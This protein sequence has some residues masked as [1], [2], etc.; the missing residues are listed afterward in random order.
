MQSA[1][2]HHRSLHQGRHG[3]Q[4]RARTPK[5]F[6]LAIEVQGTSSLPMQLGEN[7]RLGWQKKDIWVLKPERPEHGGRSPEALERSRIVDQGAAQ[8]HPA[9]DL[10]P[11]PAGDDFHSSPS[12]AHATSSCAGPGIS[13]PG[14]MSSRSRIITGPFS[15]TR[16]SWRLPCV[17][18]CILLALPIA[19]GLATRFK[20][21][22]NE[23]KILIT[24]AFITDATLKTFG[25]VLF[26]DKNGAANYLLG[27]WACRGDGGL[28]VHRLGDACWAWSTICCPS[29]SSPS[30]LGRQHR[31]SLI[32]AAY[33]AG[34]GQVPR[35]LGSDA[36]AVP[37]R[38]V[39]GQR[40]HLP[41]RRRRLPRAQSSGRGQV[42]MSA[43]LIRQTFET[44]VNWPLGAALT[45]C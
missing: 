42:A 20:R 19:Y 10:F 31:P 13:R 45:S 17:V 43:E 39:G 37:P 12:S 5:A 14:Q 28:P 3:V 6:D 40:S 23:I 35:L 29:P 25:W 38:H 24:F 33:D 34:G 27:G 26:L 15:A 18:I 1:C 9:D 7:V 36:T 41:P 44:R 4:Y 22:E 21:F 32:L 2:N 8:R 11:R 30:S 16:C